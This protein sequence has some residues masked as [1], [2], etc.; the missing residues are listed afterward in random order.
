MFERFT[1][2][3]R[4]VVEQ[5]VESAREQGAAEV[6]PEHVLAGLLADDTSTAVR[7]LVG[8]GAPVEEVWGVVAGLRSPYAEGLDADDAE[9]LKVLGID[10]DEVVRRIGSDLGG[11]AGGAASR[12]GHLRFTRSSK[13]ALELALREAIHLGDGFI[14]TEHLLLGLARTDDRVVLGTLAAFE[15]TLGDLR[16][17]VADLDRRTG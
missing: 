16:S 17:A 6:R 5:A 10:L 7:V 2:A 11:D 3:A 15:I 4:R 12:R 14:G 1:R 9:A 13:K 8:M